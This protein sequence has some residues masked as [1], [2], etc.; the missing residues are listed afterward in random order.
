MLASSSKTETRH[1]IPPQSS[2]LRP[3]SKAETRDTGENLALIHIH[4]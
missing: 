4:Q 1:P 3:A 2:L